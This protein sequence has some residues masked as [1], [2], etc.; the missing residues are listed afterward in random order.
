MNRRKRK[1]NAEN[2][3]IKKKEERRKK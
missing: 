2:K 1:M 3:N